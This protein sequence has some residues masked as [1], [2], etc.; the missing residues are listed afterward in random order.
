M[1]VSA[2][3]RALPISGIEA[4]W[5]ATADNLVPGKSIRF[6][7]P[8]AGQRIPFVDPIGMTT[9][10]LECEGVPA[11]HAIDKAKEL[12]AEMRQTFP[13]LERPVLYCDSFE[14]M[15]IPE[16]VPLSAWLD[17]LESKQLVSDKVLSF[18]RQACEVAIS[19]PMFQRGDFGAEVL[20]LSELPDLPPPQA[21]IEFF[22]GLQADLIYQVIAIS[23]PN[24][25]DVEA[26]LERMLAGWREY[27]RPIVED[28]E[29]Q[30]GKPVYYFGDPDCDYDDDNCHRFLALHCW[31]SL[32]PNSSFVHYLLEVT[33]LSRVE[34][35][36]MALI[37]PVNYIHPWKM[38]SAFFGIE[39]WPIYHF[40]YLDQNTTT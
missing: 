4:Q 19:A 39:A 38:C 25:T 32:L 28:L 12:Y 22:V 9:I 14:L 15:N 26:E 13:V 6:Y 20:R 11:D 3:L 17:I 18:L 23:K 27:I 35:L 16:Y 31:C 2:L 24:T 5:L 36:K 34:E 10:L 29:E 37:N 8:P 40:N 1:N 30:L 7:E 21:M 33:E